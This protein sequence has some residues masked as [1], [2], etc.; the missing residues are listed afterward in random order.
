[1][2]ISV[3]SNTLQDVQAD[4]LIVN[5]FEGV[6]TPAGAT[7]AIDAALGDGALGKAIALGDV[8]GK[9]GEVSVLYSNGRLAAPRVLV[10]GLGKQSEFTPDRARQA[11][12]IAIRKAAA[13]GCK[14]VA[15]IAHGAGLGGL[16]ARIAAQ[17]T[18]EGA[19]LGGYEH[20]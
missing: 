17:A 15:T 11:M 4:A 13:L 16:D 18:V 3:L 1:M 10:V 7:G 12:G 19:L 2:R 14:T 6:Q 20:L 5:L 8:R 9:H